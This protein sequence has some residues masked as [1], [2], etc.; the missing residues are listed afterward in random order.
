[1][2]PLLDAPPPVHVY[3]EGTW[4]PDAADAL[5]EDYG[6]WRSPWVASTSMNAK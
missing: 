1:M 6:G 5:V 3:A 4:G 2:Q